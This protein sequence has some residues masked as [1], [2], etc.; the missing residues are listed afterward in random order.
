MGASSADISGTLK[1]QNATIT[2]ALSA[3]ALSAQSATVSGNT[4]INGNLGIGC[5]NPPLTKMQIGDTWT[6][7]DGSTNKNIGRNT[8][9]IVKSSGK[10]I[11]VTILIC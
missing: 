8:G 3:N 7:Y 11:F 2:G 4:S 6:F 9:S 10:F 5:S 1:A